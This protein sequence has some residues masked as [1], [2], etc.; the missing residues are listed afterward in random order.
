MCFNIYEM[1]S[2]DVNWVQII[3]LYEKPGINL[4][5]LHVN[6]L[7]KVT[8]LAPELF[9]TLSSPSLH[10]CAPSQS[11]P[12]PPRRFFMSFANCPVSSVSIPKG[13]CPG[14]NRATSRRLR[15]ARAPRP[16]ALRSVMLHRCCGF[17]KLA[18]RE[19]KSLH[20]WKC[21]DLPCCHSHLIWRSGPEATAPPR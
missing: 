11:L 8:L 1:A 4:T 5:N 7:I 3:P 10:V 21:R 13:D 16:T 15:P 18:R 2:H 19:G 6:H 9:R 12:A 14:P 17:Y 20:P